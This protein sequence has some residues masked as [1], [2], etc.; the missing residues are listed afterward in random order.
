MNNENGTKLGSQYYTLIRNANRV[1]VTITNAET[2]EVYFRDMKTENYAEFIH[3]GKWYN[4]LES[5]KL[6]WAGT[7]AEGKPLP[8]GTKVNVTLQAI[9]SYYDNVEDETTLTGKGLFLTTPKET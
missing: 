9:P 3:L 7:D 4:T 2:G 1:I 6:D 8:E 5:M